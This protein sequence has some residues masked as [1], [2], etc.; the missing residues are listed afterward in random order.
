MILSEIREARKIFYDAIGNT[1]GEMSKEDLKS[2]I[3]WLQADKDL[4][5]MEWE[6]GTY[7]PYDLAELVEEWLDTDEFY[8]PYH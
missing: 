4:I 8:K 5:Y 3:N 7:L 1:Y 6:M 2:F